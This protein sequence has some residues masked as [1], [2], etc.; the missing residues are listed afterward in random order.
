MVPS[1]ISRN[2]DYVFGD[3][4]FCFVENVPVAR[5]AYSKPNE[6]TNQSTSEVN[7]RVAEDHVN[8][9][10]SSSSGDLNKPP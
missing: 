5:A 7:K 9:T 10:D 2:L 1:E 6:S 3:F 4:D 8:Q